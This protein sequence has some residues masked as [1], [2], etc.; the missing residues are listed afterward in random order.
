MKRLACIMVVVIA[1]GCGDNLAGLVGSPTSPA[2]AATD[3]PPD[4]GIDSPP[5]NLTEICDTEPVTPDDWENCY[6]KRW[7]EWVVGCRPMNKYRNVQECLDRSDVVED[8][9]LAERRERKRAVDE[10]RALINI[11]AFTQCLADTSEA[12]CNTAQSSVACA[13]RFTG[14]VGDGG[15]CHTDIECTSPGA[16]C[17]STC[18]DGCCLG[19]CHRK[20]KLRETCNTFTS[21]EPGLR[22]DQICFSGDIDTRCNDDGD[23][24][25]NAWCNAGRCQADFAPGD[26]CTNPLQCGGE[27]SCIGLTI[28]KSS[29]GRCLSISHMGDRCDYFCYGN[30]YCD[31]SGICLPLHELG[32]TCSGSAPCAGV[33]TTCSN[34]QCVLR[35]VIGAACSSSQTCLPG[36]FCTSELNDSNPVCAARRSEGQTCAA[37]SHC[38]SYMCSGNTARPGVCF[39]TSET[40]SLSGI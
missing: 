7:C 27:T 14:T 12:R 25:P 30:L 4:A 2:D 5:P 31:V 28:S 24:D 6:R 26:D 21:C 11:P 34:G 22:C 19:A 40:C 39:T 33:N 37:P 32:Q 10:K 8:G 38:E 29:P 18:A 13:T 15:S 23:C 3:G 35:S 36:L 20:F 17:D 1:A 9:R 16:T